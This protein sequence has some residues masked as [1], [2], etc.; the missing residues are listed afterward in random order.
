M[1]TKHSLNRN[2]TN[3][4][5]NIQFIPLTRKCKTKNNKGGKKARAREQRHKAFLRV[6]LRKYVPE[7]GLEIR[8]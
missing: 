3:H 6:P 8:K 5:L 7:G 1:N 2:I 4:S